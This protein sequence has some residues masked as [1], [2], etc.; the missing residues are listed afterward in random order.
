MIGLGT[1]VNTAAIIVGGILGML[2][3]KKLPERFQSTL[4]SGVGVCV[5]FLGIGGTLEKMLTIENG[6][7]SAGGS[8]MLIASIAIG[9]IIGELLNI[10]AGMERFGEFIKRKTGNEKDAKFVDG[11]VTASLTVC[12]GAMAVVGAIQD[13]ISKDPSTL[14]AKAVLDMIIILIMSSTMGKGCMFS[15]IPVLIFQGSITVL[16]HL[17]EPILTQQALS[18]LSMVGS[19]L[20]FCVGINLLWGK[21]IKVANLLP[22][23]VVAVGYAFLPF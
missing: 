13:G 18:N 4:M 8:M 9:A 11:F 19:V 10:D 20:I 7:L 3:G 2:F 21:K 17:I 22:S 6:K 5:L 1:I 12:I 15:A 23:I 14:I 16:A